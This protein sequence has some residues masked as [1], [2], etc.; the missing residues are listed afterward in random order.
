MRDQEFCVRPSL[1]PVCSFEQLAEQDIAF[2]PLHMR[3]RDR[4]FR[5]IG[6]LLEE[7]R[8]LAIA[9]ELPPLEKAAMAYM[10]EHVLTQ[11]LT[12][13]QVAFIDEHESHRFAADAVHIQQSLAT[14]PI[15]DSSEPLVH[16]PTIFRDRGDVTFDT[17]VFPEMAGKWSGKPQ[18]FWLRRSVAERLLT[19]NTLLGSVGVSLHFIEAFRPLEVQAA[20]FARRVTN[21]AAQHPEWTEEQILA[22]SMSKTASR[23]RLASHLGGAAVDAWPRDNASGK[24]LDFGHTYPSGGAL[25]APASPFVTAKQWLNRQLLQVA[26]GLAGLTMYPGEDWHVSFGDNLAALDENNIIRAEY[27]ASFGPIQDFDRATGEITEVIDSVKIDSLFE[28][29]LTIGENNV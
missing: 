22:E 23:P 19:A 27:V 25:V 8:K 29:N 18:E 6:R 2:R 20:M 11:P 28:Y 13:E 15:E 4:F 24:L 9:Q 7:R 3:E 5:Q 17:G 21:T 10:P 12:I 26:T 14:V 16:L 1:E